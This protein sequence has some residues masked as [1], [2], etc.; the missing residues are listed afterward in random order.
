MREFVCLP[1]KIISQDNF[2][3]AGVWGRWLV[4]VESLTP[5]TTI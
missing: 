4:Y 3:F 5:H 2:P 1:S